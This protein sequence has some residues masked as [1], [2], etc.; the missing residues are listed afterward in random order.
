VFLFVHTYETKAAVKLWVY[1][2]KRNPY[3]LASCNPAH[4]LGSELELG[5]KA[6]TVGTDVTRVSELEERWEDAVENGASDS[7]VEQSVRLMIEIS[8]TPA[9]TAADVAMKISVA[10][11]DIR[12]R[13]TDPLVALL[14]ESAEED[15]LRLWGPT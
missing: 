1:C 11:R 7:A 13:F 3:L 6:M 4:Y 12:Y 9:A 8:Q 14:L 2:Y 5:G 10:V 15:C